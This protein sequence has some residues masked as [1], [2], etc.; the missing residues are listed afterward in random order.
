MTAL[1]KDVVPLVGF[2][3]KGL[4]WLLVARYV[5]DA[6]SPLS[7]PA[8]PEDTLTLRVALSLWPK[9]VVIRL[10]PVIADSVAR[11]FPL[12]ALAVPLTATVGLLTTRTGLVV[13]VP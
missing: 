3:S 1:L 7:A 9:L 6:L 4:F 2:I 11:L 12:P 13:H 10:A 8:G 5:S